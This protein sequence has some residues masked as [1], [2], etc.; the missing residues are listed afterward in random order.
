MTS[1][2]PTAKTLTI[3]VEAILHSKIGDR[4][5]YVPRF[6]VNY[7][8]KIVH[9]DEVNTIL[10]R[11][12]NSFGLQWIT[13]ILDELGMD[14][15]IHGKE[16]LPPS[17]DGKHYIFVSNHPLGGPDG[18][19][20]GKMLAENYGERVR[21][22]VNDLLMNLPGLAPLCVPVNKVGKQSRGL[23]QAIDAAFSGDYHIFVFPAGLC[24]RKIDG[25]IQ[26]LPWQK[27]F[28]QKSVQY[29]RDVVPMHFSGRNSER[30]YRIASIC[31]ALHSPV[32]IAMLY[33]ADELF[34]NANKTFELTIG[35]PIPWQTFDKT[36]TPKQW[37]HWTKDEVYRLV[38]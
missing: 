10:E 22:L 1:D 24:S 15:V 31:Q 20:Y 32:N 17:D 26:D 16:N 36:R 37:A 14:I 12:R 3:D 28:I 7:L 38:K 27:T 11:H 35:K 9:Q 33:L 2:T 5:R 23:P 19:I 21:I 6:L 18:M 13:E 34:K 8:K 30:F 25:K 29:R 4:D